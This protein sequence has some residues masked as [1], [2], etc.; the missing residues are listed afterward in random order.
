VIPE[1]D[2]QRPLTAV[3]PFLT[4]GIQLALTVLVLFFLGRWLD[5]KFETAPWLMLTGLFV[6]VVGG[7]IKF[8]RTSLEIGGEQNSKD[9]AKKPGP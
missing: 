8:V 3:G 2:H 7:L 1:R 5:E 6:G 4:L 9:S